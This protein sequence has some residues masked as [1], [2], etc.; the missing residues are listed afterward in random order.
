V[1][2]GQNR[3]G[4]P[5][6]SGRIGEDLHDVGPPFDLPVLPLQ[7][8]RGPD[9]LPVR[10]REV[11]ERGDIRRGVQQHA[12]DLRELSSEHVGDDIQL[13]ADGLP[14]VCA[15]TVRMVA[16]TISPEPFSI[17]PKTSRTK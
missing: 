16:A 9:L 11:S 6:E 8:V 1:E 4:E 14:G 10:G 13:G 12:F 15:K 2:F 17:T 7:R 3:G 5:V